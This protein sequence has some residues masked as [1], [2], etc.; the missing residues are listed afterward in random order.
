MGLL[1]TLIAYLNLRIMNK[2][3]RLLRI[4][5]FLSQIN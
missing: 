1:Q 5:I 3:K 2:T 4:Y